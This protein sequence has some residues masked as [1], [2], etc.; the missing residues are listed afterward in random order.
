VIQEAVVNAA[1]SIDVGMVQRGT[2]IASYV[3][4][5]GDQAL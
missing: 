5:R 1:A 4:T 2:G 3:A